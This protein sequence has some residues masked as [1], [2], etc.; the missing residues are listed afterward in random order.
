M[1]HRGINNWFSVVHV[2]M[3]TPNR[4]CWEVVLHW[5]AQDGAK[6]SYCLKISDQV[7]NLSQAIIN[8]KD[9][10]SKMTAQFSFTWDYWNIIKF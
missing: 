3:L 2:L 4:Q 8:L 6:S 9:S 7:Y 5:V 10:M 1:D